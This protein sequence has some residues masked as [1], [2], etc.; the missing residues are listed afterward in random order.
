LHL[1]LWR[2]GRTRRWR[3][4]PLSDWRI[5]E[6]SKRFWRSST[7]L[8]RRFYKAIVPSERF[9]DPFMGREELAAKFGRK[10]FFI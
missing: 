7:G 5:E 8:I 2:T 10:D 6:R 3:V 4:E 9:K 1:I